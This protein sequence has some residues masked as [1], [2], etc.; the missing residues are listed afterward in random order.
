MAKVLFTIGY[1]GADPERVVGALRGAGVATLADVRAVALSRKRGF[2]KG[3]LAAGMAG[4]GLAYAHLRALGT[5]KAGREA[6]R[7]DDA[8]LMRRIY[9]EEVL[10]A[11]GGA[12][13]LNALEDLAAGAPTCLLCF[14]RDPERCH[15]RVLSERME[16]RGFAVVDLF[17]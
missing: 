17:A 7:A 2:S 8:R 5:P 12:A 4:A 9:C 16:A 6:A 15:R 13:A 10:E 14:E 1:E 3:A 11:E